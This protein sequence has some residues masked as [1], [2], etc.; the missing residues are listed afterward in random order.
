M[1]QET[2]KLEIEFVKE[3]QRD[4]FISWLLDGGGEDSLY[5]SLEFHEKEM[6][7]PSKFSREEHKITYG[8]L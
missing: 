6:P 7:F 5:E 1:T 8:V 2:F 4:D 3:E